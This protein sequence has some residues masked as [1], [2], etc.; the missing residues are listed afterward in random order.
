M[1]I[2]C[3][4]KKWNKKSSLHQG[5]SLV[6]LLVVISIVGLL[7][8]ISVPMV[9]TLTGAGSMTR[10]ISDLAGYLENARAAAM[11]NNTYVWVGVEEADDQQKLV[12][13]AVIGKTGQRSDL[14]N[15]NEYVALNKPQIYENVGLGESLNLVGKESEADSLSSGGSLGDFTQ[16]VSGKPTKFDRLLEFSPSG[17]VKIV[18]DT[19]SR[20][21]EI[22]LQPI[23]GTTR[24][25]HNVAALQISG[26][27]GQV[28]IFRP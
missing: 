22:G 10:T 4:L 1:N 3:K 5:F 28:R 14:N 9:A 8:S 21:I 24:N 11:A 20:W 16:N 17:Q 27:T 18:K 15:S 25:Q 19:P 13:S 23:K 26:L 6:E 7:T 12:V 2:F